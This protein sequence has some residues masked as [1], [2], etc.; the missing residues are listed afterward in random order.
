MER[1]KSRM[2]GGTKTTGSR[3]GRGKKINTQML[4]ELTDITRWFV[5]LFLIVLICHYFGGFVL[6]QRS[7]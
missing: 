5:L 7:T 6:K 3:E 1:R 4:D 2:R